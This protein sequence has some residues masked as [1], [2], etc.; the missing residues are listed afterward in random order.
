MKTLITT[1]WLPKYS[2]RFEDYAK[3]VQAQ[4]D[5]TSSELFIQ[6]LSADNDDEKKA[7]VDCLV[8]VERY[9]LSHEFSNLFYIEP[10]LSISNGTLSHLLSLQKQLIIATNDP[11]MDTGY[12]DTQ[13]MHWK[14][15]RLNAFLVATDVLKR[16]S[17]A[18]GYQG[19]F[20]D[21]KRMWLKHIVLQHIPVWVEPIHYNERLT[22]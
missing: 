2:F 5:R 10:Y 1:I 4:I 21:P 3:M 8:D 12:I 17:F 16:A 9:A 22:S 15:Y 6:S 20:L 18:H 11:K 13:V 14:N 7:F 19:D